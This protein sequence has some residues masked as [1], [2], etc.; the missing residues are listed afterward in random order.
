MIRYVIFDFDGTIA[1]TLPVVADIYNELSNEFQLKQIQPASIQFLQRKTPE[2]LLREFDIP[3]HKV[4][5][6]VYHLLKRMR[7]HMSQVYPV[8]GIADLCRLLKSMGHELY[9]ISSNSKE[10]IEAFLSEHELQIFAGVITGASAFGKH[11]LIE[12]LLKKL[13][14]SPESAIYIGDEVRDIKAAKQAKIP[15]IAVGWGYNHPDTLGQHHPDYFV[16]VPEEI[17][18]IIAD[19]R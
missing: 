12:R 13:K 17:A 4:P 1:D 19:H 7:N 5:I 10:N 6:L 15:I 8:C 11:R 3:L 2:E 18:R 16:D 9:I 14:A